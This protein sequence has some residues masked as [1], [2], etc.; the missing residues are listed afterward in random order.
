MNVGC[1]TG[2]PLRGGGHR[3]KRRVQEATSAV[4]LRRGD[5]R[6]P[7]QVGPSR[8]ERFSRDHEHTAA[9]WGD[10]YFPRPSQTA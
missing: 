7:D 5:G 4:D 10:G 9:Q 8:L 3:A 1:R 6:V 2:R